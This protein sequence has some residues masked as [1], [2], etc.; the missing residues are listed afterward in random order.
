MVLILSRQQF[1]WNCC[2]GKLLGIK[3]FATAY[4]TIWNGPNCR[5]AMIFKFSTGNAYIGLYH[6]LVAER[7]PVVDKNKY[8]ASLRSEIKASG[9]SEK[10]AIVCCN[11]A[12]NLLNSNLP[13][14]F[15]N[16][17]LA[18]A[19]GITPF[20]FGKLLYSIDDYCYHEIKIPKKNG[21]VR[22]LDIPSMDLKYIQRWILDNILNKLHVSDYANGFVKNRSILTNA[23]NHIHSEC[24][25][26][27]DLK[28]FFPTVKFE[29]VFRIFKYYGYTKE[30]SYT[31]SKLCTYRGILPQ[32]SPASPAITNIICLKLDKRLSALARK[33]EATFSR[34][35]DDITFS[36]KKAIVHL[37]PYAINIICDEGFA[38]NLDKTHTSFQHQ[39]Q[40]VTGLIV[41]GDKVHVSQKFKKR[42][43]QEIYYCKKYGVQSHLKHI[44][45]R[46]SFYKEHMYGQ[47][48]FINMVEPSLGQELLRLLDSISWEY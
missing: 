30:V 20:D 26:N 29:Q 38:V 19:L 43:R 47:A 21:G 32:G 41:N 12:S 15:D 27:I 40:E 11:Y 10:Y 46:H 16:S 33:Y 22:T 2:R 3:Q 24:V 5:D 48:Y 1:A 35:A 4:T 44:N 42:L 34:Y 45:D 14:L 23:Q 17:H 18:L 28:D 25:V 37:L 13:V 39:R 7:R 31:L 36:G 9:K 6:I 8:L